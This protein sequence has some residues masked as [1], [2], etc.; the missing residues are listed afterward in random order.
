MLIA[1]QHMG[2]WELLWHLQHQLH[3]VHQKLCDNKSANRSATS[4]KEKLQLFQITSGGPRFIIGI[5]LLDTYNGVS[6][7]SS[8]SMAYV[9]NADEWC[10][11]T[12]HADKFPQPNPTWPS[13]E[14]INV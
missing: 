8:E 9:R 2:H 7:H 3:L 4:Y 1:C 13:Y 12:N 14:F 11:T 10:R 6:S 5:K